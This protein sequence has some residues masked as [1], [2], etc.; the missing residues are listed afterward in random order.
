MVQG[1]IKKKQ[2]N[3]KKHKKTM[4][5]NS[6]KYILMGPES[7]NIGFFVFFDFFFVFFLVFWVFLIFFVFLAFFG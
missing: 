4:F 5:R 1:K 6:V 3:Q 2:K 7:W